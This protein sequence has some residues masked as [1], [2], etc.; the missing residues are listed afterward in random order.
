MTE[1][2]GDAGSGELTHSPDITAGVRVG[3]ESACVHAF[4]LG[5]ESG[6]GRWA[7]CARPELGCPLCC[8]FESMQRLCDKY[9][10]A[11]D[12]IHQLVGTCEPLRTCSTPFP[13]PLLHS[14]LHAG[15]GEWVLLSLSGCMWGGRWL[16]APA[17]L[18]VHVR[19]GRGPRSP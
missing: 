16:A 18:C 17:A 9:N 12:S 7:P 6:Q 14:G 19:S 5:L 3:V 11:I 13:Q 8:S 10:R 1:A 2:P 15:S 4:Q